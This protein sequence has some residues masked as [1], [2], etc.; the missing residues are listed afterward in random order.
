M[1]T[2]PLKNT[3]S[4]RTINSMVGTLALT[5][6]LFIASAIPASAQE[7][8]VLSTE[9]GLELYQVEK[10][11]EP[12]LRLNPYPSALRPKAEVGNF[13]SQFLRATYGTFGKTLIVDSGLQTTPNGRLTIIGW[14]EQP[15]SFDEYELE[16][17]FVA[18]LIVSQSPNQYW[19]IIRSTD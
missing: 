4:G 2:T 18:S 16:D 8:F 7:L 15:P 9:S 6:S 3:S 13:H 12:D 14:T 11:I 19:N 17:R 1:I 10:L 5:L